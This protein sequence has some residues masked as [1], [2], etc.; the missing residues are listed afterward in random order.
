MDDDSLRRGKPTNH[1]VFG[2]ANAILAGDG[3][4]AEA[5]YALANSDVVTDAKLLVDVIRDVASATGGR[6]MTGGQVIDIG[7]TGRSIDENELTKL[8]LYK[9][10]TLL[11]VSVV[12]G[13]KLCGAADEELDALARYGE[14]IGLAFQIADDVLDIEGDEE[15]L[16]K[17]IGSDEGNFKST[18]PAIIGLEESKKKARALVDDALTHISIFGDRA[19]PL[20]LLARYIIDRNK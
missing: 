6:G 10:G 13:A 8:H 20:K 15:L 1:K 9:T 5:F 14:N 11:K 7:S 2:E 19:E 17:D 16:G 18:Y 4:L 12:S 3:L